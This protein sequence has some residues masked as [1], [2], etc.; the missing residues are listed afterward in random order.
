PST[1]TLSLHDALP[2][3]TRKDFSY[4]G[5]LLMAGFLVMMLAIVIQIFHPMPMLQLA[6]SGA[7]ML[8]SAGVILFETSQIIHGGQRNYILATDRKSTRLNFSHVSI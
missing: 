8:L 1:Y 7:F 4:L 3:S 2:I 6:M 5:G